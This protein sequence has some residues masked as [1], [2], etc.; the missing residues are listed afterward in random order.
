VEKVVKKVSKIP[1][2]GWIVK[3][4]VETVVEWVDVLVKEV[5]YPMKR[6]PFQAPWIP[7]AGRY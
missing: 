3:W 5:L 4:V 6:K 2:I 1:I 7:P